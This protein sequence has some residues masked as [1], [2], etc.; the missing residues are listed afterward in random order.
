MLAAKLKKD[1][2]I[3]NRSDNVFNM[4][5]KK[6]GLTLIN[7]LFCR[8]CSAAFLY[9]AARSKIWLRDR[10]VLIYVC[11]KRLLSSVE[12]TELILAQFSGSKVTELP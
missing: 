10:K 1:F 6:L 5:S 2:V 11:C 12:V 7:L 8:L 4:E 3:S 9:Y